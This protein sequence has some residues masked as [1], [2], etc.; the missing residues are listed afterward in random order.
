[1][2][3]KRSDRESSWKLGA[4][5]SSG[6]RLC[7]GRKAVGTETPEAS[8]RLPFPV[9]LKETASSQNRNGKVASKVQ[10]SKEPVG[11][12]CASPACRR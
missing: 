8:G 7:A 2:V 11:I 12:E 3:G 9:G 6:K 4:P 10:V 1:M 5:P